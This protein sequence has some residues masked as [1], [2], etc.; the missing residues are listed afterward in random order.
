MFAAMMGRLN[1][2]KILAPLENGE[3]HNGG[4][5]A[6]MWAAEYGRLACV[7]VLA[8]LE[9]GLRRVQA[10]VRYSRRPTAVV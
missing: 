3:Q 5:T 7:E 8:P 9:N 2:V 4:W 1:C 6:V 10:G